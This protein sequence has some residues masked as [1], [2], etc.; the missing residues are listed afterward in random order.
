[1]W[2]WLTARNTVRTLAATTLGCSRLTALKTK[3]IVLLHDDDTLAPEFGEAYE[4]VIAP[5][6]DKREAGF[7]SW[8]AA[9]KFDDGRMEP[10]PY[11]D[12]QST[13]MPSHHLLKVVGARGRLS[14]SPIVSVLNRAV[15]I[16][17]CKEAGEMLTRNGSLERPGMLLGT[18]ILVYMRHIQQFR[19]WLYLDRALSFY[20]AHDGSGT[21]QAQKNGHE[22]ILTGGYDLARDL[23]E[24]PPIEPTPRLILVY[25]YYTPEDE[26]TISRH[27]LAQASWRFHFNSCDVIE[28]KYHSPGIPKIRDVLDY[29]CSMALPEDI[30]VYANADAGLT[31]LAPERIIAGV[32]R[33]KA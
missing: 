24:C 29:A 2:W 16:R 1:M 7:V 30:V 3:R 4:N 20:G 5:A 6:M 26:E 18:E 9:L 19:R 27:E 25:S 10:C 21:V 32:Q 13:L 23:G 14:L 12:G 28:L 15:L 31:T 22:L 8:S 33:V 11:W 17:A